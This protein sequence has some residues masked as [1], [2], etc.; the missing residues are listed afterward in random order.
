MRLTL[1]ESG[2]P[3]VAGVIRTCASTDLTYIIDLSAASPLP[4]ITGGC[5][6]I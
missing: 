3:L 4:T 2:V 1:A 6:L 5:L